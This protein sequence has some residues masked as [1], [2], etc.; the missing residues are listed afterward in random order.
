[1]TSCKSGRN[2]K[3]SKS[4]RKAGKNNKRKMSRKIKNNKRKMSRKMKNKKKASGNRLRS[5]KNMMRSRMP[6]YMREKKP[7][8]DLETQITA[9]SNSNDVPQNCSKYDVPVTPCNQEKESDR[10]KNYRRLSFLFH[11]DKVS[12]ECEPFVKN[13]I[14]ILNNCCDKNNSYQ[15]NDNCE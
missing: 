11:P 9:F 3:H 10:R 1:M 2:H 4:N 15:P 6:Q 14:T 5:L 7:E 13:K 8:I 12:K